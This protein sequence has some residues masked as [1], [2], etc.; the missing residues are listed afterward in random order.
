MVP[1]IR[2]IAPGR[3]LWVAQPCGCRIAAQLEKAIRDSN[4]RKSKI[5]TAEMSPGRHRP[6]TRMPGAD[7]PRA[8]G[9]AACLESTTARE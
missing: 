6:G 1:Q 8:Y 9:L 4:P 7:W 3:K 5:S 2:H